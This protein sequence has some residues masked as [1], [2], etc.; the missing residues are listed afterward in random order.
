[1][2]RIVFYSYFNKGV[3][4]A[5]YM[6]FFHHPL[7]IIQLGVGE[8]EKKLGMEK[9]ENLFVATSLFYYSHPLSTNIIIST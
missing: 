8:V 9:V 2:L 6:H 5:L 4:Y 7:L 1:M 3:S